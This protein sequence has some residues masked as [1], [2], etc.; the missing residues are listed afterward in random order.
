M[1]APANAS[2]F[3][4]LVRKSGLADERLLAASLQKLSDA[5][6]LP[7]KSVDLARVLVRDGVLT[8][9]QAEQL[10]QG[11]WRRF[12]IGNYRIL[13]PLG[14]GGMGAVYLCEHKHMRRRVAI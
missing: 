1:P 12:V 7:D 10:L 2:E 4:D 14:A 5:G 11:R 8:R 13:Q 3:L 9:F 6:P